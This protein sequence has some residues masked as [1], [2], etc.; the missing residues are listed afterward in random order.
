VLLGTPLEEHVEVR[1]ER[2]VVD[3]G[4]VGTSVRFSQEFLEQ[5]PAPGRFYQDTLKLAP[6][7]NDNDGDGNPNVHGSG[8]ATSAPRSPA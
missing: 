8:P 2:S 3:L 5:L 7:V 4:Q 6:G 1:G